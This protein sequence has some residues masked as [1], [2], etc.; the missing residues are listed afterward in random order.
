MGFCGFSSKQSEKP[1][2]MTVGIMNSLVIL[3]VTISLRTWGSLQKKINSEKEEA[4]V[5]HQEELFRKGF[6]CNQKL[7]LCRDD[8]ISVR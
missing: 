7:N 2:Q 3:S 6:S 8:K 5:M 4:L 1:F